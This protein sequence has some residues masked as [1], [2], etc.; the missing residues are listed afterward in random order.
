MFL[1][2]EC[3]PKTNNFFSLPFSLKKVSRS[4]NKLRHHSSFRL[5]CSPKFSQLLLLLLGKKNQNAHF[6]KVNKNLFPSILVDIKK[7]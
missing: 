7:T 3:L 4:A 2:C 1:C 5:Q 6:K